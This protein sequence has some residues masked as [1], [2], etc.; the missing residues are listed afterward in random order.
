MSIYILLQRYFWKLLV[1]VF[2][3]ASFIYCT[4]RQL[5]ISENLPI[6]PILRNLRY[7][8]W[9]AAAALRSG[10]DWFIWLVIFLFVH[11]HFHQDCDS[12]P[13]KCPHVVIRFY[14]LKFQ[15]FFYSFFSAPVPLRDFADSAQTE[16]CTTFHYPCVRLQAWHLTFLTYIKAFMPC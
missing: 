15:Y 7:F 9:N 12:F 4:R 2:E 3:V 8:K 5:D 10:P 14:H 6:Y 13:L 16:Y 1:L 11:P